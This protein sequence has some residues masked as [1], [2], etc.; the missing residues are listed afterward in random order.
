MGKVTHILLNGRALLHVAG[1]REE[2]ISK[3]QTVGREFGGVEFDLWAGKV[4][5]KAWVPV[6]ACMV[7]DDHEDAV[8]EGGFASGDGNPDLSSLTDVPVV[9]L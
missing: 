6:A 7:M 8:S 2:V 1:S 5:G 9:K 4:V 3:L